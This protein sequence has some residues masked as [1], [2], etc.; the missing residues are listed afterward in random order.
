MSYGLERSGPEGRLCRFETTGEVGHVVKRLPT[1]GLGDVARLRG[2]LADDDQACVVVL[3]RQPAV[4]PSSS[5]ASLVLFP[6]KGP[7]Q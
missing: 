6:Q 4:V 3:H 5:S 7:L 2:I 1:D